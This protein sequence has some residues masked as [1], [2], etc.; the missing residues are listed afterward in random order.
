MGDSGCK[1]PTYF[2]EFGFIKLKINYLHFICAF[3][4]ASGTF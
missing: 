1:W 4:L 3:V 2:S